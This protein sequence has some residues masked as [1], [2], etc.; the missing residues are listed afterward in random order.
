MLLSACGN[1][2]EKAVFEPTAEGVLVGMNDE[3]PPEEQKYIDSVLSRISTETTRE[4]VISLLGTPYRDLGGKVN[5][6]IEIDGQKSRV[7]VYFSHEG[8]ATEIVLD[9]GTGRYYY[10]KDLTEYGA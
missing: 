2:T 5:W 9:G 7:G 1:T 3:V 8:K 6:W 10:R 4:D